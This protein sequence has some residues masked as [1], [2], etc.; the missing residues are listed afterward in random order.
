MTSAR[1]KSQWSDKGGGRLGQILTMFD[2]TYYLRIFMCIIVFEH[3]FISHLKSK[4]LIIKM[5][6]SVSLICYFIF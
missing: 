6:H 3:L 2:V 5:I 1:R 4:Y